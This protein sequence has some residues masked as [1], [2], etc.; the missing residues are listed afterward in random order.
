MI[1]KRK[2]MAERVTDLL[3]NTFTT[4]EPQVAEEETGAHEHSEHADADHVHDDITRLT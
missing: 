2:N 4:F 1:V 3:T